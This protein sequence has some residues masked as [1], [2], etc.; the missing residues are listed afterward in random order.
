MK[1]LN[2][3]EMAIGLYSIKSL[4]NLILLSLYKQ[5]LNSRK[6]RLLRMLFLDLLR[7]NVYSH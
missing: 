1:L 5:R 7:K 4:T 3:R 2:V 6:R